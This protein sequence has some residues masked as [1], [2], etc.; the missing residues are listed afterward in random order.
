MTYVVIDGCIKCKYMD[1]VEVCPVDCF[2]AG[3]NMLVINP[4]ECIDCG[5]CEPECPVKAIVPDTDEGHEK[6][7]ELNRTLSTEWPNITRKAPA[8]ADA[9][10]FKDETG[11]FEKYFSKEP[12]KR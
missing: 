5:V 4:D 10:D 8:P 7:L 2:Y 6:F 3:E 12:A 1:C 11:K 9:D